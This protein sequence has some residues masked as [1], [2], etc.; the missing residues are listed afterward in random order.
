M[1]T[2]GQIDIY[3]TQATWAER[4]AHIFLQLYTRLYAESVTGMLELVAL[5]FGNGGSGTAA[6]PVFGNRAFAVFRWKKTGEAGITTTRTHSIYVMIQYSTDGTIAGAEGPGAIFNNTNYQQTMIG[7]CA[8]MRDAGGD[9]SP[10]NGT[11]LANGTD[12]KGS[13]VWNASS[14]TAYVYPRCN[15]ASDGAS[16]N[17]RDM[18]PVFAHYND[19]P[20]TAT[21]A[22]MVFDDDNLCVFVSDGDNGSYRINAL[23]T[24]TP[25]SGLS[26]P[27]PSIAYFY[28]Q[29][30]TAFAAAGYPPSGNHFYAATNG[31]ILGRIDATNYDVVC[32]SC[33]LLPF[34]DSTMSPNKQAEPNEYEEIPI[35][36][37][38]TDADGRNGRVGNLGTFLQMV[39]NVASHST[40]SGRTRAV[41]AGLLDPTQ[42]RWTVGWDGATDPGV[43]VVPDGIAF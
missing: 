19:T 35:E 32:M 10:W 37:A 42:W 29:S 18:L 36:A 28:T 7:M 27:V 8:A 13:P 41:F 15:A 23:L 17:R 30:D 16:S 34:S 26:Y 39:S 31:G 14:G 6:A 20:P 5:Q 1:A 9:A 3:A 22:H 2:K 25:R 33:S 4:T 12:T 40:N 43:S 38:V 24:G 11:T 21:R